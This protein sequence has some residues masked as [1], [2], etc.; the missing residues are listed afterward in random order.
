[1]NNKKVGYILAEETSKGLHYHSI[2]GGTT[3]D[4]AVAKVFN[5]VEEMY[6]L[7]DLL[8]TRVNN[9]S[10]G[11]QIT[12]IFIKKISV[13]V[14]DEDIDEGRLCHIRQ[15]HAIKRLS[16]QEIKDLGIEDVACLHRLE[17]DDEEIDIP[18]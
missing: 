3:D 5:D 10:T 17:H 12:K 1:M 18:F 6:D 4:M 7:Y 13:T 2:S 15:K 9:I 16:K 8:Y 11:E 14:L